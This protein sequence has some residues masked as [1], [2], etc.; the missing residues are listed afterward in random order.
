MGYRQL[1]FK[2]ENTLFAISFKLKF[3]SI[4]GLYASHKPSKANSGYNMHS[5][6]SFYLWF[7]F[8]LQQ[9]NPKIMEPQLKQIR[10]QQKERQP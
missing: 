3:F 10:E 2:I 6:I 8:I 4:V 1:I 5:M 9:I 7:K